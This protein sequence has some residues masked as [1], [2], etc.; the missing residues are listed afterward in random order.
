KIAEIEVL[1]LLGDLKANRQEVQ[2]HAQKLVSQ[3][4]EAY[5]ATGA[6]GTN[7]DE[8]RGDILRGER[9]L[10]RKVDQMALAEERFLGALNAVILE[11]ENIRT[12]LDLCRSLSTIQDYARLPL[13]IAKMAA[14]LT[15][16]DRALVALIDDD[17][18]PI[19]RGA[20]RMRDD[21]TSWVEPVVQV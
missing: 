9:E 3:A 13:D 20:V 1:G 7:A 8:T 5:D 4:L 19:M 15:G 17:G 16:A 11:R 6:V 12:L 2:A 10:A 21:D 14:Q 18:A